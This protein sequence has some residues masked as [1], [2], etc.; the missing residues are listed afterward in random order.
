[1]RCTIMP[2]NSKIM[3]NKHKTTPN[4][5]FAFETNRHKKKNDLIVHNHVKN[6]IIETGNNTKKKCKNKIR[7]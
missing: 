2:K 4:H 1:M 5:S 6:D 7:K 3:S